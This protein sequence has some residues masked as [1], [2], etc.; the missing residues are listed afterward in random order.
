MKLG[1][2][3]CL[4]ATAAAG[5][6]PDRLHHVDTIGQGHLFR[7]SAPI[8]NGSF[9][10]DALRT[11]MQVM[12]KKEAGVS[13]PDDFVLVVVSFLDNIKSSEAAEL[14]AEQAWFA[15]SPPVQS[16]SHLIHWPIIGDATSPSVY[17][18][19]ICQHEAKEYA[20][21]HDGM[22]GKV[23]EIHG[24]LTAA[25]VPTVVY[26]HCDAGMD[27]T[28]EMYGDYSMQYRNM[29]YSEGSASVAAHLSRAC[30]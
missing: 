11:Q 27:R 21:S 16:G 9:A 23:N 20:S 7:G 30:A 14:K 8:V 15:A 19:S 4:L 5:W 13:V 29:T 28:G 1:V 10:F 2:F 26:F 22:P 17:P 12:A 6:S 18:K 3:S 24:I 25:T